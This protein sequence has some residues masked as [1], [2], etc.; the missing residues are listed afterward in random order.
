MNNFPACPNCCHG[1]ASDETHL[2]TPRWQLEMA[3]PA[4]NFL[5]IHDCGLERLALPYASAHVQEAALAVHPKGPT[6]K[7]RLAH[8]ALVWAVRTRTIQH[9][10]WVSLGRPKRLFGISV[11]P[12][13][14]EVST[15]LPRT[16]TFAAVA[17][18]PKTTERRAVALL[19]DS[20]GRRLAVAKL[21][22]DQ[23]TD[24]QLDSEAR[25][26]TA[27][28]GFAFRSF[29]VPTLLATGSVGG[30]RYLVVA[31]ARAGSR[32]CRAPAARH[33]LTVLREMDAYCVERPSDQ[34]SWWGRVLSASPDFSPLRSWLLDHASLPVR[35]R[36]VHGD[37]GP[38]NALA[39]G[40]GL[41]LY[42]W[43]EGLLDGPHLLDWLMF[44]R[45]PVYWNVSSLTAARRFWAQMCASL[46][47]HG[48][49]CRGQDLA[50]AYLLFVA[51]RNWVT[52]RESARSLAI[53]LLEVLDGL[54][55][56]A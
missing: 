44:L 8:E 53:A 22:F 29:E 12:W 1:T 56:P 5:V 40:D 19:L 37:F 27:V 4:D 10:P 7:S 48:Q 47:A 14:Q 32:Q 21:S 36:L 35:V 28:A 31:L 24:R 13:L 46:I 55:R 15:A 49:I 6:L 41:C 39:A 52:G 51:Q 26:L 17:F 11:A 45:A 23:T 16:A 2:T 50:A 30:H 20:G 43:E 9:L 18:P 3:G 42:D 25:V 54:S 34:C 33:L 38:G